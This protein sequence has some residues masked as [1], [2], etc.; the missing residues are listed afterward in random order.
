MG[1]VMAG[2]D[3][4]LK[5]RVRLKSGSMTGV[6]CFSGYVFPTPEAAAAA[7]DSAATSG[8]AVF[9]IMINNSLMS[10]YRM[11][12]IIDRLVFLITADMDSDPS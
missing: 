3:R 1:T 12:K 8:P 6:K 4:S 5:S 9:S 10:Q 11:Q 7:G 2:Y